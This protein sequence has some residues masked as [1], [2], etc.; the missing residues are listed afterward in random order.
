MNTS[1]VDE[2]K[3]LESKTL[4]ELRAIWKDLF[5]SDAPPY[6]RKYLITRIAYRLQEIAYGELS[7]KSTKKLNDLA[8]Q[9]EKGKGLSSSNLPRPGTKLIREYKGERHEVLVT[10]VGLVYKGQAYTSLSAVANRITGSHWNGL[11]F[12]KE[13]E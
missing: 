6:C 1:I 10:V 12:F 4:K 11:V 13:K 7:R 9:M 8:N 3:S 5:Q 2:V